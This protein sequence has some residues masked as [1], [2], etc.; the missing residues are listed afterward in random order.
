MCGAGVCGY[1][2]IEYRCGYCGC[3]EGSRRMSVVCM[4]VDSS[5]VLRGGSGMLGGD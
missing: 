2:D 1:C 3:T 5:G 4:C